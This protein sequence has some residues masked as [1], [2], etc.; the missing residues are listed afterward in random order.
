MG[1][2]IMCV[3]GGVIYIQITSKTQYIWFWLKQ[4]TNWPKNT[5]F[6]FFF[7]A[8]NSHLLSTITGKFLTFSVLLETKCDL[9]T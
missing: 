8:Q 9:E 7:F 5:V 4:A 2:H 3:V 6:F 1:K